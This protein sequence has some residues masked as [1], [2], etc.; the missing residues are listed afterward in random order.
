MSKEKEELEETF[1]KESKSQEEKKHQQSIVRRACYHQVEL[2]CKEREKKTGRKISD[3][4]IA[5]L[6]Q[7]ILS[8]SQVLALDLEAFAL[9]AGRKTILPEDVLLSVRH[10]PDLIAQLNSVRSLHKTSSSSHNPTTTTSRKK[11]RSS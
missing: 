7:V 2:I 8:S 3:L 4:T 10:S 11:P 6:S 5:T 1:E 9:H